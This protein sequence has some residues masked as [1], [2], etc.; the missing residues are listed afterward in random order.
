LV[1]EK[2]FERPEDP[3]LATQYEL[4]RLQTGILLFEMMNDQA[5]PT[6]LDQL[7]GAGPEGQHYLDRPEEGLVSDGWGNVFVFKQSDGTFTLYSVGPDGIDN[8]GQ[9]DDISLQ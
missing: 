5:L 8:G 1:V 6:N 9:G 3:I 2:P 4:Q 7:T